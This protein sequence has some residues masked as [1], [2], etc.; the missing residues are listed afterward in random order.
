MARNPAQIAETGRAS[1]SPGVTLSGLVLA[2]IAVVSV[3]TSAVLI[4]LAGDITVY[5]IALWRLI[6]AAA[7][8]TPAM[9]ATGAWPAMRQ[10]GL[11]RFA[12]YGSIL[13]AHF[14]AYNLALRYAP[15]SHVLPLIYTSTIFVAI[16]SVTVL[17]ETLRL[18]QIV[19]IGIVLAGI[20]VLAGFDPQVNRTVLLGNGFAILTAITFALYA[21]VGRRERNRVPLL[22][23]AVG[24]YALAA[25]WTAPLAIGFSRGGYTWSIIL[26]LL[27]LGIIPNAIGHTLFNASLRRLNATVANIL[28]T[29]EITGAII[30][31]W[32]ILG[33][34]PTTNAIVGAGI[35]LIGIIAVLL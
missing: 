22:G 35:M 10:I 16:L 9:I 3:S 6:I 19:G 8:L 33:E 34:V 27:A 31:G 5:E 21:F 17:K 18:R 15:I 23:Y 26:A 25:L 1:S 11:R 14:I 20:V 28:F 12:L 7:I 32:L 13:S 2:I 24:V 30:L 29:Q 4:R